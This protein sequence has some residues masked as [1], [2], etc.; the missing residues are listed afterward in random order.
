MYSVPLPGG[1][2]QHPQP[3]HSSSIE[4]SLQF[5]VANSQATN[6]KLDEA[7]AELKDMKSRVVQLKSD[8]KHAFTEIFDLKEKL[9][10]FEQRD[11]AQAFRIFGLPLGEEEKDFFL[12]QTTLVYYV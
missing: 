6:A 12:T 1:A 3:I 2:S 4:Q 9:N 8:V 11:R 7:L 5:L 10:T